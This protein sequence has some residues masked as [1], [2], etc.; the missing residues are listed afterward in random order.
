MLPWKPLKYGDRS[1]TPYGGQAGESQ[2]NDKMRFAALAHHTEN[3]QQRMG[4]RDGEG[5]PA[6]VIGS[7]IPTA[8]WCQT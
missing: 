1:I 2:Q 4:G 7:I 8:I 5:T 6:A 3:I